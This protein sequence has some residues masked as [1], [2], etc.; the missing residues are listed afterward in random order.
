MLDNRLTKERL[1]VNSF[2]YLRNLKSSVHRKRFIATR[3]NTIITRTS[4]SLGLRNIAIN[5]PWIPRF[6]CSTA[7]KLA[8]ENSSNILPAPVK[9]WLSAAYL[10]IIVCN[11]FVTFSYW[12]LNQQRRWRQQE[13]VQKR[14]IRWTNSL[15]ANRKSAPHSSKQSGK[16]TSRKLKSPSEDAFW[17]P[18]S[19]EGGEQ[20]ASAFTHHSRVVLCSISYSHI[21]DICNKIPADL[22]FF[23]L[24]RVQL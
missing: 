3:P 2:C 10:L 24:D 19:R 22:A 9:R 23:Q 13:S 11:T 8:T 20:S 5:K 4:P 15:T 7:N 12:G 21:H 18:Q 17:Q 14:Q 16:D 1:S 6:F